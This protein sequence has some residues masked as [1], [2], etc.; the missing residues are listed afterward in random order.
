MKLVDI[1]PD[2]GKRESNSKPVG[3]SENGDRLGG[4]TSGKTLGLRL[5]LT[6]V[7]RVETRVT[8]PER[9]K[10]GRSRG[11]EVA[12]SEGS[13]LGVNVWG[14]RSG[15]NVDPT[16]TVVRLLV[17]GVQEVPNVDSAALLEYSSSV[18][19][20]CY[21]TSNLAHLLDGVSGSQLT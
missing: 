2:R 1:L 7:L 15:Q 16:S 10:R 4:S 13:K 3:L 12:N 5:R 18:T 19:R 11:L 8:I 20:G 6:I 9:W 17:S 14:S 21:S